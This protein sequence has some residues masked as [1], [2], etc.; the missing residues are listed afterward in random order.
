MITPFDTS[1]SFFTHRWDPLIFPFPA[2]AT[3]SH[4]D[5]H[6]PE[7][8][9][10]KSPTTALLYDE[11]RTLR[12]RRERETQ[13]GEWKSTV[14][15]TRLGDPQKNRKRGVADVSMLSAPR[16]ATFHRDGRGFTSDASPELN[17][18]CLRDR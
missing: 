4:R 9:R 10:Q 13:K 16:L 7:T 8:T 6:F 5:A 15:D 3:H 12:R 17:S 11:E 18:F 2:R 1:L 14:A